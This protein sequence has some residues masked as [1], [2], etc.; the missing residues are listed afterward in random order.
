VVVDSVPELSRSFGHLT[1]GV[2]SSA[3]VA[4]GDL[5][6]VERW[7]APG[8]SPVRVFLGEAVPAARVRAA[9]RALEPLRR[10]AGIRWISDP[11]TLAPTHVLFHGASGWRLR[12]PDGREE[13]VGDAPRAS[14]IAR[15]L[16]REPGD[17]RRGP[18]CDARPC[19]YVRLPVP[20]EL[21]ARVA[22]ASG[23]ASLAARVGPESDALYLLA[24]RIGERGRPEFAWV[25][26]TSSP[27]GAPSSTSLPRRSAWCDDA[28][29]PAR[30]AATLDQAMLGIAR[31]RAWLTLEPPPTG[32]DPFPYHLDLQRSGGAGAVEPMS[33]LHRGEIYEPLLVASPD[34]LARG[35]A[36]RNV[37][38]LILDSSGH[39]GVLYPPD[40]VAAD[41]RFPVA[42]PGEALPSRILLP[43]GRF[44]VVDPL[45]PDA[46]LLLAT[47]RPLPA[48]GQLEQGP[49]TR[50]ARR[51]GGDALLDLLAGATR[52]SPSAGAWS[53]DRLIVPSVR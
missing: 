15:R 40:R 19:L 34:A 48:L 22:R 43:G 17:P 10:A 41:N 52:G 24:G 12:W 35:S 7:A 11:S 30:A 28:A 13:P 42:A 29:E 46:Y 31:V 26:A 23:S 9:A 5:F 47:E 3:R 53:I 51:D 1:S 39:I 37:Y 20:D 50:G 2:D 44:R 21:D 38:V 4:P 25:L 32:D 27:G 16:E 36:V 14:T 18:P 49:V 45:G 6:A 33:A 8:R